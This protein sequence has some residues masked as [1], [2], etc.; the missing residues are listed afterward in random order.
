MPVFEWTKPEDSSIR[1]L[2]RGICLKSELTVMN[3]NVGLERWITYVWQGYLKSTYTA[4]VV[5]MDAHILQFTHLYG[6]AGFAT[7]PA[8]IAWM[9]LYV[10]P[11]FISF[12]VLG[13]YAYLF[14]MLLG[15][16]A[17]VPCFF[18]FSCRMALCMLIQLLELRNTFHLR[19]VC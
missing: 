3:R 18:S 7:L 4:N 15:G 5:T 9:P 2:S 17:N 10:K 16:K 14:V 1:N 8:A 11:L 13:A 19:L 12:S 6:K